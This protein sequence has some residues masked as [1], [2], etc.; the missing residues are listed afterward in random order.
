MNRF[1]LLGNKNHFV[2]NR[3]YWYICSANE[4]IALLMFLCRQIRQ[5]FEREKQK[6]NAPGH[7]VFLS[8][9]L[10]SLGAWR[11]LSATK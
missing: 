9:V 3:F 8:L 6:V 1:P 11:Y 5:I 7:G 10:F 4:I 2:R